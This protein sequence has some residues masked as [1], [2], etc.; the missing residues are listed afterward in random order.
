[1][2]RIVD[3][4]LKDWPVAAEL[5]RQYK[6]C[7]DRA[8]AE[9]LRRKLRIRQAIGDQATYPLELWAWRIGDAV[10]AGSLVEA[11]SDIQ[12]ALRAAFPDRAIAWMNLVN[13]SIGYLPPAHLYDE[14]LY[15]VWQTPFDRGSLESLTQAAV[16][17]VRELTE[18]P[19]PT[20]V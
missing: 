12:R 20:Q 14:D 18:P 1:V 10:I 19:C 13:G 11:Y 7:P 9:R 5:E 3:L 6:S 2:R 16:N 15:Q 17:T 4:P 8:L